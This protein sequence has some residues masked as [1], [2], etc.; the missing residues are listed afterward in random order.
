[1]PMHRSIGELTVA[2]TVPSRIATRTEFEVFVD[3]LL[4]GITAIAQPVGKA[5]EHQFEFEGVKVVDTWTPCDGRDLRS[6][7]N[8]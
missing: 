7:G 4:A 5:I 6:L 3:D 2:S 8:G 1:M